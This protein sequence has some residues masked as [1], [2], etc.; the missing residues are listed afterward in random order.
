MMVMK[1]ITPG[2]V[3]THHA[4]CRTLP[5]SVRMLPQLGCGVAAA[6]PAQGNSARPQ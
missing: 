5:P 2:N 6:F 4:R 3:A 1:I